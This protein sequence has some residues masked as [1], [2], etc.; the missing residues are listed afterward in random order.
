MIEEALDIIHIMIYHSK[1]G[2]ISENMWKLYNFL[3]NVAVVSGPK[4]SESYG[5]DYI[6]QISLIV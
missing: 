2:T 6:S 3:L 5:F 1:K 4:A